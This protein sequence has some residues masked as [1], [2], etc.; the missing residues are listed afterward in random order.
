MMNEK[1]LTVKGLYELLKPLVKEYGDLEVFVS[2][3]CKCA[4]TSIRNKPP[5]I[6]IQPMRKYCK[7]VFEGY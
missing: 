4:A 6:D 7:V 3:D 5:V 1:D 2:Y